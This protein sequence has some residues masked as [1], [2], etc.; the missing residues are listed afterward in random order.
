MQVRELMSRAVK[1]IDAAATVGEAAELMLKLDVGILPVIDRGVPTGMLTDRDIVIRVLADNRDTA[2]TLVRDVI[3]R[4]VCS[5]YADQEVQEAAQV[6]ATQQVRRLLVLDHAQKPIGIISL[7]DLS[8][9]AATHEVE[10]VV[11]GVSREENF[12]PMRT[13]HP[14]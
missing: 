12:V 13:A 9:G 8:R 6:M 14:S 4:R 7:G 3:T 10:T 5:V 11:K 1:T 2:Q